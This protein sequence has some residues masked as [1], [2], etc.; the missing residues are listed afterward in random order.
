MTTTNQKV[1]LKN[2]THE[3]I[4]KAISKIHPKA[5]ATFIKDERRIGHHMKHMT[6]MAEHDVINSNDNHNTTK[7]R[8]LK[9]DNFLPSELGATKDYWEEKGEPPGR[10]LTATYTCP[11]TGSQTQVHQTMN[12]V[13]VNT[14]SDEFQV[15]YQ[16]FIAYPPSIILETQSELDKIINEE[17]QN[18]IRSE[19]QELRPCYTLERR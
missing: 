14:R 7:Q 2:C 13:T 16:N 1:N 15:M 8:H 10:L 12:G 18:D 3:Q 17:I 6:A 19:R 5:A 4:F 11:H 9:F